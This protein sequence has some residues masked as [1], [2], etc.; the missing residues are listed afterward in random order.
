MNNKCAGENNWGDYLPA[1]AS[2]VKFHGIKKYIYERNCQGCKSV[3]EHELLLLRDYKF[4]GVN[5]T[6]HT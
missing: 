1:R 4:W 3:A 6:Y 2:S 5:V